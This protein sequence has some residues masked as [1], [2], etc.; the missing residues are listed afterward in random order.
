MT[1][2][3]VKIVAL[4]DRDGIVPLKKRKEV[5]IK[6]MFVSYVADD[7]GLHVWEIEV[8]QDTTIADRRF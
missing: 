8:F 2:S 6:I 1:T 5:D 3:D 4:L 7:G